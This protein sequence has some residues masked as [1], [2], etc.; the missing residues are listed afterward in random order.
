MRIFE[1][2][3]TLQKGVFRIGFK[4]CLR[5]VLYIPKADNCATDDVSNTIKVRFFEFGGKLQNFT[6]VT[7]S[8]ACH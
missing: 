6:H 4:T 1:K 8:H 3:Q 7:Q 2:S 5:K